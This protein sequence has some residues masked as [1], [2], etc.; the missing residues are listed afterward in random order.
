MIGILLAA[1]GI[2]SIALCIFGQGENR[3]LLALGLMCNSLAL[4]LRC[5]IN[6][7]Q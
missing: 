3:M 1:I 6:R 4:L 5:G 2:V 7:I